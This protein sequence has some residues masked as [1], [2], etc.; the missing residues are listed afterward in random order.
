MG[1]AGNPL[2]RMTRSQRVERFTYASAELRSRL[3][4]QQTVERAGA[5]RMHA[6]TSAAFFEGFFVVI[7][8]HGFGA[9]RVGAVHY[10]TRAGNHFYGQ[11]LELGQ[12]LRRFQAAAQ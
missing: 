8:A 10:L 1:K 11:A 3:G 2:A 5:H 6:D 9:Q 7:R 4:T 12:W